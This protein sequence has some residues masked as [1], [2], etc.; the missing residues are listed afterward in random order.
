LPVFLSEA[1]GG[2]QDFENTDGLVPFWF[3][4]GG[5]EQI[6][7]DSWFARASINLQFTASAANAR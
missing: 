3:H 6:L 2:T 7:A 1:F 5:W 4:W